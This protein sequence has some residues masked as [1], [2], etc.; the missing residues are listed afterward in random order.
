MGPAV[1]SEIPS[2][3]F[4]WVLCSFSVEKK[5]I[6]IKLKTWKLCRGHQTGQPIWAG[7]LGTK[8]LPVGRPWL[9][10][11]IM[12]IIMS[13]TNPLHMIPVV[14]TRDP[15]SC[16]IWYYRHTCVHM[17]LWANNVIMF[18]AI[19]VVYTDKNYKVWYNI[20]TFLLSNSYPHT[21][22]QVHTHILMLRDTPTIDI[23]VNER[24]RKRK[25]SG[26][27]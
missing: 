18:I 4:Y 15:M 3:Q 21:N 7:P 13:T 27:N 22:A 12:I 10:L 11:Q 6:I 9:H 5:Q 16:M 26:I 24:D 2:N 1:V 19:Y 25:K 14:K 17:C 20:W 8:S 23:I